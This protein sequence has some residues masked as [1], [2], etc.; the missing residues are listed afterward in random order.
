MLQNHSTLQHF[1]ALREIC[2]S[3]NADIHCRWAPPIK[4]ATLA[5][6]EVEKLFLAH[7]ASLYIIQY[8]V[9]DQF[10]LVDMLVVYSGVDSVSAYLQVFTEHACKYLLEP[11]S[12]MF[13]KGPVTS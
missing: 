10:H 7:P 6:I 8:F 12:D 9:C 1:I 2:A 3:N 11:N 5:F 4:V 13:V